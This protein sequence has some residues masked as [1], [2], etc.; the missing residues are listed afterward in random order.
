M[1]AI[2]IFTLYYRYSILVL[3]CKLS[4]VNFSLYNQ[5]IKKIRNSHLLLFIIHTDSLISN[6]LL[7]SQDFMKDM[8][9]VFKHNVII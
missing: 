1:F 9:N 5:E 4:V 2:E 7:I 8:L 3:L 6:L